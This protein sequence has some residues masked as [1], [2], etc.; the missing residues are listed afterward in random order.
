MQ[1]TINKEVCGGENAGNHGCHVEMYVDHIE[2][3][4]DIAVQVMK[5]CTQ[6]GVHVLQ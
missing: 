5:R 6:A 1:F 3:Q 4:H 2:S